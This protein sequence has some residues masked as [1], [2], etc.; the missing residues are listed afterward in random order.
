MA[1]K[2]LPPHLSADDAAFLAARLRRLAMGVGNDK[3]PAFPHGHGGERF[4]QMDGKRQPAQLRQPERLDEV[5]GKAAG[6]DLLLIGELAA[7]PVQPFEDDDVVR[8][9]PAQPR[10]TRPVDGEPRAGAR[11][12]C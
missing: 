3:R 9:V 7:G 1:L 10:R 8:A 2:V 11:P 5:C 12:T 4:G 6:L